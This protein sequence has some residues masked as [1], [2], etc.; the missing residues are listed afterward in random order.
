[1]MAKNQQ[2]ATTG[3]TC[4][5]CWTPITFGD[6]GTAEKCALGWITFGFECATCGCA[7]IASYEQIGDKATWKSRVLV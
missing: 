2:L 6:M 7:F 5:M 1:M 3:I 4:P